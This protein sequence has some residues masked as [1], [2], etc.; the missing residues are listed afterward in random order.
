MSATPATVDMSAVRAQVAAG[1][2][3]NLKNAI[4]N[5]TL[6]ANN[7]LD[8][9]TVTS[10]ALQAILYV[11]ASDLSG[12][13]KKQVVIDVITAIVAVAPIADP[14]TKSNLLLVCQL[15]LP[16]LIDKV[17]KLKF[18]SGS[19]TAADPAAPATQTSCGCVSF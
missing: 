15:V 11:E 6:D 18:N 8:A 5:K 4:A 9:N 1:L 16:G 17:V 12:G 10:M 2:A 7:T 3:D 19:G 14:T 13:D